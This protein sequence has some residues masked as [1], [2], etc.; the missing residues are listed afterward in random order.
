MAL[1]QQEG[2]FDAAAEK[3]E[4][5]FRRFVEHPA[6]IADLS[7]LALEDA[8]R[9]CNSVASTVTSIDKAI[10]G[11]AV[12]LEMQLRELNEL[13]EKAK[14][15]RADRSNGALPEALATRLDRIIGEIAPLTDTVRDRLNQVA[16]LQNRILAMNER[17]NVLRQGIEQVNAGR[18][19]E[20]LRFE[21]TPLWKVTGTA[22]AVTAR[23]STEFAARN[24]PGR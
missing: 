10:E 9:E 16:T 2:A 15:L 21:Q 24:I 20:L 17:I 1:Q 23:N 14:T 6:Q 22:V 5:N 13:A 8:T 4:T 12:D 3:Y 7:D 18:R 11:S 19:V